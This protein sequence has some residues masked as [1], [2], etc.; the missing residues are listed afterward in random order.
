MLWFIYVTHF[1]SRIRQ[2]GFHF[3]SPI[4]SSLLRNTSYV[5]TY[6]KKHISFSSLFIITLT[7]PFWH[8]K[9]KSHLHA[10]YCFVI[11]SSSLYNLKKIKI[12]IKK[13]YWSMYNESLLMNK[14]KQLIHN[15][16][17]YWTQSIKTNLQIKGFIINIYKKKS[18]SML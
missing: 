8:F 4:R 13:W 10:S 1:K 15:Y 11:F 6:K 9:K 3:L 5:N 7:N 17:S 16:K 14:S 12:V 18:T 2:R